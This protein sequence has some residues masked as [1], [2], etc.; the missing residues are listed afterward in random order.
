ML[1]MG[2][3]FVVGIFAVKN[4]FIAFQV[5]YLSK[6]S[7]DVQVETST[8]LFGNTFRPYEFFLKTNTSELLRN[9]IIG[10]VNSFVGYFLQPFLIMVSEFLILLAVIGLLLY[11]EPLASFVAIAF[12]GGLGWVFHRFTRRRVAARG[13]E[14][15]VREGMKIK[16]LQEGFAGIKA[17]KL[18]ERDDFLK[19]SFRK[20]TAL[21][22]EAGHQ[23][24]CD[25][26]NAKA[27]P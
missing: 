13:K 18:L 25:P 11:A 15:Q 19:E 17:I 4:L 27:S 9:S 14:R 23:A 26:T 5:Y 21:G 16:C 1:L 3:A 12:V 20:H 10:E 6:Y 22:A 7:F 2:L 8:Y 24:I